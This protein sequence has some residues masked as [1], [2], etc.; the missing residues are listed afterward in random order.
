MQIGYIPCSILQNSSKKVAIKKESNLDMLI[1]KN[2]EIFLHWEKKMVNVN[3]I[4]VIF[5]PDFFV[6][7][8]KKW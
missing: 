5:G 7:L 6:D 4:V 2:E 1:K 3:K 8:T